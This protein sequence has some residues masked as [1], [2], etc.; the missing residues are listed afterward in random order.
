MEVRGPGPA[1][2]APG[3]GPSKR[4]ENFENLE[5]LKTLK[6][7]KIIKTLKQWMFEA[8]ASA[9]G[10]GLGPLQTPRKL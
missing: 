7:L 4:L 9:S 1:L 10:A 6:T 3:R 5:P 8:P 2:V